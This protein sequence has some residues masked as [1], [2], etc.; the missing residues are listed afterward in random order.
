M[1]SIAN[2]NLL[3]VDPKVGFRHCIW[4]LGPQNWT[5]YIWL[6]LGHSSGSF[7]PVMVN[8]PLTSQY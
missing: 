5:L 3:G 2:A 8:N 7:A 1:A 4:T 6:T